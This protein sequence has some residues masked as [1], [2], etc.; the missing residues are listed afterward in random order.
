MAVELFFSAP[1]SPPPLDVVPVSG[2]LNRKGDGGCS[3]RWEEHQT[4]CLPAGVAELF[5]AWKRRTRRDLCGLKPSLQGLQ[6]CPHS[7]YFQAGLHQTVH[8]GT[9]PFLPSGKTSK[10]HTSH[11]DIQDLLVINCFSILLQCNIYTWQNV[12]KHIRQEKREKIFLY[13]CNIFQCLIPCNFFL[14]HTL[15]LHIHITFYKKRD[16]SA[17]QFQYL[18]YFKI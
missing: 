14:S 3:R 7:Y 12:R 13:H 6:V 17:Y 18:H 9:S 16:P 4:E 11:E 8:T 5:S 2:S 10:Q 1:L 15:F